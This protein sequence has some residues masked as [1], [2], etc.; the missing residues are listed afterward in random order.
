[1]KKSTNA[2]V[3]IRVYEVFELIL[4]GVMRHEIMQYCADKWG[5]KERQSF[6]YVERARAMLYADIEENAEQAKNK[7]LRELDH[8]YAEAF[9]DKR[10]ETCLGIRR[11]QAT[12]EGLLLTKIP[13]GMDDDV[14]QTFA[15]MMASLTEGTLPAGTLDPSKAVRVDTT[16]SSHSSRQLPEP[17]QAALAAQDGTGSP[18]GEE[19]NNN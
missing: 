11:L 15:E 16:T 3:K 12:L 17:H 2:E 19:K 13:Q 14:P 6:N 18:N 7:R 1:V 9:R 10:W 5:I 8:L 4:R